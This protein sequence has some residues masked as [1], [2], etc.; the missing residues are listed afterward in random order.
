MVRCFAE[1]EAS[2][3]G[4]Q[5]RS[6]RYAPFEASLRDAPQGEASL[7][8]LACRREAR[9]ATRHDLAEQLDDPVDVLGTVRRRNRAAQQAQSRRR[10]GRQ[11]DVHIDAGLE[12]RVPHGDGRRLIGAFDRDDRAH[13][14]A[15]ESPGR[16][17]GSHRTAAPNCAP[18]ARAARARPQAC[19]SPRSKWRPTPATTR[20]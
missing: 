7:N 2:N 12:Q 1:G 3:H 13:L 17:R 16:E 15:A 10:S 11:R 4:P 20:R 14:I 9:R 8:R 18:A 5:A 19:G 6:C